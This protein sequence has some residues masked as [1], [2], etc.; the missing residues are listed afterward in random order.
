MFRVCAFDDAET[1]HCG[2]EEVDAANVVDAAVAFCEEHHGDLDYPAEMEAR[3]KDNSG[4]VTTVSVV[5]RFVGT[6]ERNG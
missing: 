1:K 5:V 6:I 2:W 4:K 3:V